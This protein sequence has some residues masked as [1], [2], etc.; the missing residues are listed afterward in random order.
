MQFLIKLMRRLRL[1]TL[2]AV[3]GVA[4]LSGCASTGTPGDPL[5]PLNRGI[6]TFNDQNKNELTATVEG[7]KQS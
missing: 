3:T 7:Q 6:Y 2:C 5:E 1:A 4:I